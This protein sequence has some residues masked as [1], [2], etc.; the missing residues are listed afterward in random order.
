MDLLNDHFGSME[1]EGMFYHLT[2]R[3][4]AKNSILLMSRYAVLCSLF[5]HFIKKYDFGPHKFGV[6]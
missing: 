6:Y 1:A 2:H 3:Q 5:E 4:L